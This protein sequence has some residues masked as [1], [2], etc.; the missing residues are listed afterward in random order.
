MEILSCVNTDCCDKVRR[1]CQKISKGTVHDNYGIGQLGHLAAS[2]F[3]RDLHRWATKQDWRKL[4]PNLYDFP[5]RV[6]AGNSW[7]IQ[8]RTHFAMLPH[9][10]FGTVYEQAPEL[11]RFLWGSQ[12]QLDQY[13]KDEQELDTTWYNNHPVIQS[14]PD[15]KKRI[16]VGL[17]GDD[18][19]MTGHEP[20]LVLCW[21]GL[22]VDLNTID[23]RLLFSLVRVADCIEDVTVNTILSVLKW[24]LE[25]LA[26][27]YYPT[28]DHTGYAF[29]KTYQPARFKMAGKLLANG[30][31][32]VWAELRGDWKFLKDTLLLKHHYSSAPRICHLCEA[33]KSGPM[34]YSDFRA[35]AAY[36]ATRVCS[37]AWWTTYTAYACV[38]A[39][40]MI[41][42]FC[43]Y[44]VAFDIMHTVDLGIY[45]YM[46]PSVLWDLTERSERTF[47][48]NNRQ[49][50]FAAA[51]EEYRAW[52]KEYSI[53]SVTK[54][55]FS[56]KRFR[57]DANCY[58]QMSQ[59]T[60]KAAA[61]RC[62]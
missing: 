9:E 47:Q 5:L 57:P 25:A 26:S 34:V 40:L 10:I 23:N 2:N 17:H 44:R 52:C 48:G 4:L 32:A 6:Y 8:T 13:W 58:P 55:K 1:L 31:K 24:S 3:E 22:A 59:V 43:I 33:S 61:T 14:E 12:S 39:L 18:A 42:G 19:G 20:V 53:P 36:L 49:A 27:G 62:K 50:R 7:E 51:Y 21:N 41:P 38:C 28:H 54:K 16:P 46:L 56:Y 11:F 30:F 29:S 60:A 35:N 15:P 37:M 45:Q